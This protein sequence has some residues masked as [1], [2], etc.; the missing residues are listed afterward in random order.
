MPFQ[1][2]HY[3]YNC[4]VGQC[5]PLRGVSLCSSASRSFFT[6]PLECREHCSPYDRV[7]VGQHLIFASLIMA[8]GLVFSFIC[9]P[10]DWDK[11]RLQ[12]RG[13]LGVY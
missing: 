9:L 6:D 5:M 4:T 3:V 10:L 2:E 1:I 13:Q 12:V 7:A 11:S 8:L